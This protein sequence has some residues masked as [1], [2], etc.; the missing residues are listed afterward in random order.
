MRT[1]VTCKS[2]LRGWQSRL[3]DNYENSYECWYTYAEMFGLHTRLGFKS[4]RAAWEAN[5]LIQG[6]VEPSDFQRVH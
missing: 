4:I 1:V 6:S 5:P 3:R 2:G